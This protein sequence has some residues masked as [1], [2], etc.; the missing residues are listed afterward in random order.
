LVLGEN[1]IKSEMHINT[2][3]DSRTGALFARNPYNTDF[4][5]RVVFLDVNAEQVSFTGDRLEFLGRNGSVAS[6]DALLRDRLSNRVGAAMDPCV[7][8]QVKIDLAEGEEREIVFTLG[9]GRNMDDARNLIRRFQGSGSARSALEAVWNYWNHALGAVRVETPDKSL[10]VLTNGWLIY[11]TLACR[12]WAR[13]GY[14]QSGGAF[15]FRDQL[16]DSM[17]LIYTDPRI[18][19]EH[20]LRCAAH[21]FPDG[22]VLHWW[23]PP[24]GRGVRTHSSD[25]RLWLPLAVYI[26]VKATG[27]KGV[28]DERVNFIEGR[29]LKPEEEA[30]YDLPIKSEE[31]GTLYEHCIRAIRRSLQLGQHGLPL[32]GSGD[33]NDSMNRVGY[34]GLGESV[35]LA[36][37]LYHVLARF[38]EIALMNNDKDFAD[39]CKN[40]AARLRQSIR[41]NGWDG[42]WYLRAYFDS[43][44]KLG[45]SANEECQIDS[46]SQSWSVLSGAG[47]PDRSK[48]AMKEVDQRLVK[49]DESLIELLAPPFDKS[50]LDPGYIKG[51]I[52]GVR[53]NGGQYTHAAIWVAMA[54]AAMGDSLR[55]WKLLDMINPLNHS[56]TPEQVAIYKTEPYVVAG[57]VYAMPPHVGRGGWTWYTGASGWMYRLIVESLLGMRLDVDKLHFAPCIPPD[58][59]SFMLHYRYIETFYHI[60]VERTGKGCKVASVTVD[61]LEQ[62]DGAVHLND[63]RKE[64]NVE[65]KMG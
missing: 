34:Q 41:E 38:S 27:D 21:Q 51:Y 13:S 55:A 4:P 52:P 16:Q 10:D 63:D 30:N 64:H 23:H 50:D 3:I 62:N 65:I 60:R 33:W 32:M 36:F 22:D 12:I 48:A 25:D 29:P 45:S 43:G 39:I 44:E 56:S 26:Y 47:D 19:R 7:A 42:H 49:R 61:G 20:L 11:Q 31:S 5:G 40:E 6:P 14:Y 35:W 18:T 28:L 53:E 2:E 58:W 46:I 9:T 8:Q 54:F 59:K 1:R 17:A 57:D 37:F 15:G 24:S